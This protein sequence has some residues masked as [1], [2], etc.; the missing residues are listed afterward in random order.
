[1]T[2]IYSTTLFDTPEIAAFREQINS[3]SRTL[4]GLTREHRLQEPQRIAKYEGLLLARRP[5]YPTEDHLSALNKIA[6]LV[7]TGLPYGDHLGY[8]RPEDH[9]AG[10]ALP[11]SVN[12]CSHGARVNIYARAPYAAGSTR[13]LW[14]FTY[15]EIAELR[16]HLRSLSLS[17]VH[18]WTHDDGVAF[19]VASHRV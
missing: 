19:V 7:H 15:N 14:Q 17:I 11:G 6:L 12:F 13:R 9:Q 8:A 1:M 3:A 18:E 4:E 16:E 2:R 10:I 5:P